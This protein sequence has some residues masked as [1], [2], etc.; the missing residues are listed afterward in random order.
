MGSNWS[1]AFGR[2]HQ[3][4]SS[5]QL[6]AGV[7]RSRSSN[8]NDNG[9]LE[10]LTRRSGTLTRSVF[11]DANGNVGSRRCSN[12]YLWPL[13]TIAVLDLYCLDPNDGGSGAQTTLTASAKSGTNC[14]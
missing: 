9:H 3:N 13:L 14:I 12:W 6:L 8:V 7:I 10:L 4:P 1:K 11:F 5:N 2:L